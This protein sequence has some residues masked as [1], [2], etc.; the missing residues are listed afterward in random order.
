MKFIGFVFG[1]LTLMLCIIAFDY[2]SF[3]YEAKKKDLEQFSSLKNQAKFHF[4]SK[5]HK[6]F[7]Y[8]Q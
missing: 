8:G 1:C 3:D 6:E 4:K 2:L 5:S 7:I